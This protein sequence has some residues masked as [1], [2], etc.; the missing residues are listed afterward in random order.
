MGCPVSLHSYD[1]SRADRDGLCDHLGDVPW[2]DIF[3]LSASAAIDEFYEL[4]QLGIDVYIPHGK[5]H[6]PLNFLK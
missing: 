6:N 3:K 2:D 1:Y 4:V 5:Y